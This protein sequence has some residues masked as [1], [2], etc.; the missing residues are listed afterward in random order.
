MG[1]PEM[2]LRRLAMWFL[3]TC[4]PLRERGPV[5]FRAAQWAYVGDAPWNHIRVRT[6]KDGDRG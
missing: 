2:I 5:W 1:N 3:Y 4:W 6:I